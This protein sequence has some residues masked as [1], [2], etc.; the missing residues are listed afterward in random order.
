MKNY[1]F[2]LIGLLLLGMMSCG[3]S[4]H[5]VVPNAVS[6]N[7]VVPNAITAASLD[8]IVPLYRLGDGVLTAVS[9]SPADDVVAVGTSVGVYIYD[10]STAVPL[11]FYPTD[12]PVDNAAISPDGQILVVVTRPS[13]TVQFWNLAK[14]ELLHTFT[15]AA[16]GQGSI[17]FASDGDRLLLGMSDGGLVVNAATGEEMARLTLSSGG[18][19]NGL[20]FSPDTSQIAAA[21]LQGQTGFIQFW[22]SAGG[23]AG[24]T[25]EPPAQMQLT[26]GKFSP[27]GTLYG[28]VGW[29]PFADKS[30]QLVIWHTAGNE[31]GQILPAPA[32][33]FGR[34]WAF[35]PD[36]SL[37]AAG[38]MDGAVAVWP[39]DAGELV[40]LLEQKPLSLATAVTFTPDGARLVVGRVN[41]RVE[42]WQAADGT[43]VHELDL[44]SGAIMQLLPRRDA[45]GLVAVTEEGQIIFLDDAGTPIGPALTQHARGAVQSLAFVPGKSLLAAGS[46]NGY[47]SFWDLAAQEPKNDLPHHDGAVQS[48]AF[49]PMKNMLVTAVGEW[50]SPQT[51]DDT[52]RLWRWPENELTQQFGGEKENVNGCSSFR[53]VVVYSPDGRF[54]AYSSHNFTAEVRDAATGQMIRPLD[55]HRGTVY[56]LTFSPDSRYLA[57]ASEDGFV[58]VWRTDTFEQVAK[59]MNGI[60]GI[61]A[62]A[63]SPDGRYLVSGTLLGTIDLWDTAN[64]ELLHSLKSEKNRFSSLTF[65][66]DGSL[67]AA[68]VNQGQIQL[69]AAETLSPVRQLDD[70]HGLVEAVAF[71]PD[72]AF[73]AAGSSDGT[74]QLWGTAQ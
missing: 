66:P 16:A 57:T 36:S 34:A 2:I 3:G 54:L 8:Q 50:L 40:Q 28:A 59:L 70:A 32:G 31:P 22:E 67:L 17:Q 25:L 62:V 58:R 35:A 47:V 9:L 21:V 46:I 14:H 64:W 53:G 44:Q 27:D 43:L 15:G 26:L 56:G 52:V 18:Q 69:W 39:R 74:I 7:A 20:T 72:G 33:I 61:T 65:S 45:A 11:D 49:S 23:Q 10:G 29:D 4:D 60:D 24:Q 37:I 73:L 1:R 13:N 19:F 41:G 55:D 42:I 5:G 30:E 51:F 38:L 71:S 68:G 63:F 6:P 12:E 48:I